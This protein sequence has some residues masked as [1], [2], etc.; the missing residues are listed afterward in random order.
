VPPALTIALTGATGFLGAHLVRRLRSAGHAVRCLTRRGPHDESD[1]NLIWVI[2]DLDSPSSLA[3]LVKNAD[4]VVHAAGA[5]KALKRA[6]FFHANRDGTRAVAEAALNEKVPR[7]VFVSSLAAREPSLSPYAASKRSGELVLG[8]YAARLDVVVLRP[9][10]IY[11]PGDAES[12][13]LFQMAING[14]VLAPGGADAKISLIHVGDVVTAVQA[15][16]EQVQPN[17]PLE[18]DDGTPGGHS[19]ADVAE[20]AGRAV[21]RPPKLVRLPDALVWLAGGIGTVKGLITRRP[22]MLTLSKIPELLH[23]DWLAR[24]PLPTGWAP[25]WPLNKG[26]D[27][28]ADWYSSQNVLKRYL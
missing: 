13:R 17:R 8:D 10:A 18:I 11:G 14:F 27:D 15:C 9:P 19:W 25:S 28:A 5:I 7:F 16:C 6:S 21:G 26:F 20:T 1:P 3:E 4:V 23:P 12:V 24:G 2:G 22:A